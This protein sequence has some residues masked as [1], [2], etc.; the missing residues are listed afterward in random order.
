M[1]VNVVVAGLCTAVV[2]LCT[3]IGAVCGHFAR[4]EKRQDEQVCARLDRLENSTT[5]LTDSVANLNS[6]VAALTAIVGANAKTDEE[7]TRTMATILDRALNCQ[8]CFRGPIQ[9]AAHFTE[10]PS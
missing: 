2:T 7:Q 5:T 4:K 6:T 1:E 10:Q 3:A 9:Q 8:Q